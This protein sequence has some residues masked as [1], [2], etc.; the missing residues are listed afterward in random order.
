M[1]GFICGIA[2]PAGDLSASEKVVTA[3]VHHGSL[4]QEL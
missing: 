1:F 3:R 4:P 2:D